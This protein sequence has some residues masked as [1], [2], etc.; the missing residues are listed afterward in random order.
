MPWEAVEGEALGSAR[1]AR[2]IRWLCHFRRHAPMTNVDW[3]KLISMQDIP[4]LL[5]SLLD[6]TVPLIIF[7]YLRKP[8]THGLSCRKYPWTLCTPNITVFRRFGH[9]VIQ[10]KTGIE[11]KSSLKPFSMRHLHTMYRFTYDRILP[12][13]PRD[14]C[15]RE[16]SQHEYMRIF[17]GTLWTKCALF[18][19]CHKNLAWAPNPI[20]RCWVKVSQSVTEHYRGRDM[21]WGRYMGFIYFEMKCRSV[22][23]LVYA[24]FIYR[25][26]SALPEKRALQL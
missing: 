22:I 16:I 20:P 10:N 9:A 3:W 23:F 12:T 11:W 5:H 19:Y 14:T 2:I 24:F 26:E 8:M 21:T 4:I 17:F 6:S 7:Y 13:L 18:Y 1:H 15:H 25:T